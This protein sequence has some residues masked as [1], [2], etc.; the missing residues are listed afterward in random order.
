M[1]AIS[2]CFF[3]PLVV[4]AIVWGTETV[5]AP[6]VLVAELELPDGGELRTLLDAEQFCGF[7]RGLVV[8]V[9]QKPRASFS[10]SCSSC[11]PAK[12]QY[13]I[14]SITCTAGFGCSTVAL[15]RA[16]ISLAP[17]TLPHVRDLSA[18]QAAASF[19]EVTCC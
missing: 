5:A 1:D 10:P 3:S 18:P 12:T 13:R 14:I 9:V 7:D 11:R 19:V 8:R 2:L 17:R 16:T 4:G 15:C 6:L